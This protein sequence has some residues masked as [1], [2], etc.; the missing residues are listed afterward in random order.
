MEILDKLEQTRRVVE[1]A[2]VRARE[3]VAVQEQLAKEVA[4]RMVARQA[5][6][7]QEEEA[8][9]RRRLEQLLRKVEEGPE[10]FQGPGS[11]TRPGARPS[12]TW[13]TG[14]TTPASS[15]ERRKLR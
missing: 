10:Q 11:P 15:S 7:R 4:H 1:K 8:V 2:L 12:P 5:R 9:W 6:V 13:P 14:S 3:E